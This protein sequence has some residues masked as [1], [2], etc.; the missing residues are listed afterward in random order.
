M[1]SQGESNLGVRRAYVP[2]PSRAL[3]LV[4]LACSLVSKL[5]DAFPHPDL[6]YVPFVLAVYALPIWYASTGS[7]ASPACSPGWSCSWS[8]V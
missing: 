2:G 5:F 1:T 8:R 4:V 6:G 3:V 7:A